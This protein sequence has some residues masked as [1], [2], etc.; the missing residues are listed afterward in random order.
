MRNKICM[1]CKLTIIKGK[2][3][4]VTATHYGVKEEQLSKGHYH[5]QCYRE[6]LNGINSLAKLQQETLNFIRG[7]KRKVGIED[8]PVEVII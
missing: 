1:I 3:E 5:I 7:A 4:F 2:D 8:E 6:R